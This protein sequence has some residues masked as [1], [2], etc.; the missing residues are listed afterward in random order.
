MKGHYTPSAHQAKSERFHKF[1]PLLPVRKG[2]TSGLPL[3]VFC[4]KDFTNK[5]AHR[6]RSLNQAEQRSNCQGAL[7]RV[8]EERQPCLR[9]ARAEQPPPQLSPIAPAV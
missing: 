2:R 5:P 9:H 1:C 3:R 6:H 8:G 4:T 7:S